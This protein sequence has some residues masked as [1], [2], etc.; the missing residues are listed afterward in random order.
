M[1]SI[2]AALMACTGAGPALAQADA[3]STQH[4]IYALESGFMPDPQ[5]ATVSAGGW[6]SMRSLSGGADCAGYSEQTPDIGLRYTAGSFD[7]TFSAAGSVDTTLAVMTPDERLFCDDDSGPGL[8]PQ[9]TI[10]DPPSGTYAVWVGVYQ[11]GQPVTAR[12]GVSEIGE[13]VG[14]PPDGPDPALDPAYGDYALTSGFADDPRRIEMVAGGAHRAGTVLEGCPG[15]VAAAPDVRLRYQAG[16]VLPLIL[17]AD[18]TTDTTLL[19]RDPSGRWHCDDDGGNAAFN[20]AIEF[21]SP[22]SGAYHIWV[23]TYAGESLDPATL[24]ISELYS[25]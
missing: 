19:V 12:L 20:P 22:R 23:G 24:V 25:E 5:T 6:Q 4:G 3:P 10:A 21:A 14:A 9:V 7:L 16:D 15:W 13:A 18:S 17:S 11:S 1:R 2:I 8:N